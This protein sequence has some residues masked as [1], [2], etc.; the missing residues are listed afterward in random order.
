VWRF[1]LWPLLAWRWLVA[2]EPEPQPVRPKTHPAGSR[3]SR[4]P[5]EQVHT[6]LS[7][8]AVM[9]WTCLHPEDREVDD[10]DRLAAEVIMIRADMWLDELLRTR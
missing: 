10:E 2:G 7:E 4:F 8:I 9:H 1:I 3:L 6:R 5:A